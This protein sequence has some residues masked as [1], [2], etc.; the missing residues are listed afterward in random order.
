MGMSRGVLILADIVCHGVPSPAIFQEWL[1][2]LEDVRGKTVAHYEHR[3]KSMGWGH[4]ERVTFADGS[5]EQGTRWSEAWKEYFYDNRSLRSSCYRCPYTVSKGRPGD[6]TIADFWGVESTPLAGVRDGLGVS[7]V[8]ANTPVGLGMLSCLDVDYWE[9]PLA[10]ALP[11]NPMLERPST[12]EGDR[13]EVWRGVYAYGLLATMRGHGF[14]KPL[15][16]AAASRC[17]QAVKK[18]LER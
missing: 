7:F 1:R 11:G 18:L 3:P 8:L 12:Y 13:R 9:T 16:R 6:V 4:F 10:D 15:W 17:K 14:V 5:T 2:A